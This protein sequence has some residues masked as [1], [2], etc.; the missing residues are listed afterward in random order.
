MFFFLFL[1][2]A[3]VLIEPEGYKTAAD[4]GRLICHPEKMSEVEDDAV[5]DSSNTWPCSLIN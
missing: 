1:L 2:Y 3:A 5:V 4:R